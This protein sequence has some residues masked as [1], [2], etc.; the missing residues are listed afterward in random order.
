MALHVDP[1]HAAA[2]AALAGLSFQLEPSGLQLEGR[3]A[4]MVSL[5]LRPGG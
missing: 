4:E 2:A 1:Q 5:P 3:D